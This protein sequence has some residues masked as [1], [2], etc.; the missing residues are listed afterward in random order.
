MKVNGENALEFLSDL[1]QNILRV[2]GGNPAVGWG[3]IF[4]AISIAL[5][6]LGKFMSGI[7]RTLLTIFGVA[8]F[9][10]LCIYIYYA[11]N[12]PTEVYI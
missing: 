4:V 12:L 5:A 11:L 10:G 8:V 6:I 1:V 2:I 7:F 3:F 9:V